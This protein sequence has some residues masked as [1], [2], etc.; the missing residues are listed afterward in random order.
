MP[1]YQVDCIWQKACCRLHFPAALSVPWLCSES[2]SPEMPAVSLKGCISYAFE[3]GSCTVSAAFHILF[4]GI[5]S[6]QIVVQTTCQRKSCIF[7]IFLKCRI[8]KEF[9]V[10]QSGK[11]RQSMVKAWG[12][13]EN[14]SGFCIL[15]KPKL[16]K[17]RSSFQIT[18]SSRT[19]SENF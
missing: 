7:Q 12:Q 16:P 2:I 18:A 17:C 4:G 1:D 10:S 8:I 9:I 5:P 14:L 6:D 11:Q 3:T 19:I 13:S 15:Q